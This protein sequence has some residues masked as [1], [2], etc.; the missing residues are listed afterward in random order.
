MRKALAGGAE[1]LRLRGLRG[2]R[3]NVPL[4]KAALY[5]AGRISATIIQH[6][7]KDKSAL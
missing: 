7:S 2:E 5:E 6:K 3:S 1:A 4:D